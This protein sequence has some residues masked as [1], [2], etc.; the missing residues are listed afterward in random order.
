MRKLILPILLALPFMAGA[1]FA[2]SD[3]GMVNAINVRTGTVQLS[4]GATYY[5]P[6]RVELSRL[7]LGDVVRIH[8]DREKGTRLVRDIVKTGHRDAAR[9]VI[10]PAAG[11]GTVKNFGVHRDMCQP[12]SENRNPCY[13]IGGQ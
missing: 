3:S 10:T 13:D 11:A 9:T 6:N 8:Y 5:A 7:R 12:T 1:A 4:D 2:A